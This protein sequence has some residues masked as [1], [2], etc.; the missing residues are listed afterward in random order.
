LSFSYYSQSFA[1]YANVAVAAIAI[2]ILAAVD[3]RAGSQDERR[4]L[5]GGKI[6]KII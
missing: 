4:R 3:T 5:R 2:V 6:G 1:T